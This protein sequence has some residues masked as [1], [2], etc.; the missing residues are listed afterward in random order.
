VVLSLLGVIEQMLED[1]D[2]SKPSTKKAGERD[3]TGASPMKP[4]QE[5]IAFVIVVDSR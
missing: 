3:G 1:E 5:V 4:F 2:D